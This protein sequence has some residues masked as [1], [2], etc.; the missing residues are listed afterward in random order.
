MKP[1][2]SLLGSVAITGVV[3]SSRQT[4]FLGSVRVTERGSPSI[5]RVCDRR[6]VSSTVASAGVSGV[7][8]GVGRCG[9]VGR[10]NVSM[11]AKKKRRRKGREGQ[12]SPRN[13]QTA[14]DEGEEEEEREDEEENERLE[15]MASL[16]LDSVLM[17]PLPSELSMEAARTAM[18]LER[19]GD[20]MSM[21]P[22]MEVLDVEMAM[23]NEEEEE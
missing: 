21:E 6:V 11:Q 13:E 17:P 7:F 10:V 14:N 2:C 1:F 4:A 20:M 8:W 22:R 9:Q 23:G 12:P 18:E 16:G 15:R 3:S 19:G 5:G